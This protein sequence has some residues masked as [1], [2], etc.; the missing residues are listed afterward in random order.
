MSWDTQASWNRYYGGA[1]LTYGRAWAYPADPE[2]SHY[3]TRRDRLIALGIATTDRILIGGC[4]F[5]F[6]IER[7]HAAG[8]PLCWGID[9]STYIADNRNTEISGSTLWVDD[10]FTG[11]G[12]IRNK[13][14]QM[15]GDDIFNWVITESVLESLEDIEM[16]PYFSACE[17]VIDPAEP[18]TNIV[19]IVYV[20]PF[21]P[22]YVGEFNE[23]TIDQWKSMRPSHTWMDDYG[24]VR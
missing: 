13:L 4:G 5:G 3:A 16:P 23:K 22:N 19:H 1:G 11:G 10:D 18:L 2:E 17:T 12:R 24:N 9:N 8:Y 21:G 14:R 6:L 7:F 15:T 20:P